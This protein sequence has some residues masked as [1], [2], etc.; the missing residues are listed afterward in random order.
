MDNSSEGRVMYHENREREKRRR[1][2]RRAYQTSPV[3]TAVLMLAFSM[4][5][6]ASQS[7]PARPTPAKMQ[8]IAEAGPAKAVGQ[9]IYVPVYSHIYYGGK[10]YGGKR[11]YQLAVTLSI[12][13]TDLHK[14]ILV[15]SVRYYNTE[16]QLLQ[17][18]LGKPLPLGPLVSTDVFIEEQDIRG[19]AGANFLIEW[20]AEEPVNAPLVEAVMIGTSG[21]QAISFTSPGRVI[22]PYPR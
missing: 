20:R 15:T 6:V 10:S 3:I 18:Y 11:Q 17:E 19:G 5:T 21:T 22:S 14:P 9:I 2:M 8:G 7:Q 1:R 13:N 12:R 4:S 16:G